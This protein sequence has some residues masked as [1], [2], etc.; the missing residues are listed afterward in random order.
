MSVPHPGMSKPVWIVFLLGIAS[1]LVYSGAVLVLTI[2]PHVLA[3]GWLS[4]I[5]ER[6]AEFGGFYIVMQ[7]LPIIARPLNKDAWELSDNVSSYIAAALVF[8]A[9]PIAWFI[10]GE[11]PDYWTWK[12][13]RGSVWI[14]IAD[15]LLTY[16]AFKIS[17]AAARFTTA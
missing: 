5:A 7:I 9:F 13:W 14:S 11:W 6:W 1:T 8:V 17:R 3:S 16:V 4:W 2:F 10:R 15:V 12:I